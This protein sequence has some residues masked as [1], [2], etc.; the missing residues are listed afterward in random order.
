M[1]SMKHNVQVYSAKRISVT[2]SSYNARYVSFPGTCMYQS[3]SERETREN[4]LR[5]ESSSTTFRYSCSYGQQE[6]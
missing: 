5:S 6:K 2:L 1:N 3:K 4:K